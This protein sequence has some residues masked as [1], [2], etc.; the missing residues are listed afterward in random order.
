MHLYRCVAR[1]LRTWMPPESYSLGPSPQER[2][3]EL[4]SAAGGGGFA[5][6]VISVGAEGGAHACAELLTINKAPVVHLWLLC[7]PCVYRMCT[8]CT[9]C[10]HHVY[11]ACV[12]CVYPVYTVC[13]LCVYLVYTMF[14]PRVYRVFTPGQAEEFLWHLWPG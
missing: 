5:G 12:L 10:A 8:M 6:A 1:E 4:V 3:P 11:T 13:L 7:V 14:T 9:P 2:N